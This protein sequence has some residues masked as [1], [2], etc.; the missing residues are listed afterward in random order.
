M[1]AL[2]AALAL[3]Q[4][5]D[6]KAAA[7]IDDLRTDDAAVRRRSVDGL[8][9]LGKDAV[10]AILRVL[11]D[12][13]P[14]LQARVGDLVKQLA[15]KEWKQRDEAMRSLIRLGRRAI[16]F[17]KTHAENADP[18]VAWRVKTALAEI[19]EMKPREN[20]LDHARNAALCHV[21]GLVGDERAV[22][23]LLWQLTKI[24]N[25]EVKLRAA[26]ALGLLRAVMN[27]AQAEKAGDEVV[28]TLSG[29]RDRRERALLVKTLGLLRAKG[30]VQQLRTLVE[31]RSER[32]IHIKKNAMASL[33]AIGDPD[34]F[35]SIVKALAADDA[36]LREAALSV[37]APLTGG[38][39]AFDP[40]RDAK[41]NAEA[42][43]A[44][45]AWWSRKFSK[46]WKD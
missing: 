3:L 39:L 4:E 38:D 37:L 22:E 43:A 13:S 32:D 16:D 35:A 26:Q 9:E 2:L 14:G 5:P 20:A 11:A 18:E 15:S 31:E 40:R 17:L 7:L 24:Q 45:K 46:E 27:D 30:A 28:A 12:E 42:I 29:G 1:I 19:E 23:P 44:F 36:Y 33:A 10:G 21:L 6:T 8:I 34:G 41:E 25:A